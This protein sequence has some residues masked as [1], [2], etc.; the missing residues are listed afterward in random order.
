[1]PHYGFGDVELFILSTTFCSVAELIVVCHV[2]TIP[3]N[4]FDRDSCIQIWLAHIQRWRY[5]NAE[6]SV[7]WFMTCIYHWNSVLFADLVC[8]LAHMENTETRMPTFTP[9]CLINCAV[10]TTYRFQD[11]SC[12]ICRWRTLFRIQTVQYWAVFAR[13]THDRNTRFTI[14]HLT[15]QTSLSIEPNTLTWTTKHVSMTFSHVIRLVYW[16]DV[17]VCWLLHIMIRTA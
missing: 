9:V 1:M 11:F 7:L 17:R 13:C 5:I 15:C 10:S 14:G 12:S 6:L 8:L 2:K 3:A 4:Y 16:L